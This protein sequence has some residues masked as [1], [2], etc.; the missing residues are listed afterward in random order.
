MSLT[1]DEMI[2]ALRTGPCTVTFKKVNGD[3]RV[4][5]CTLNMS[6]IPESDQ[7]KTD[8]N[9]SENKEVDFVKAYDLRAAGW[10]SFKVNNV[11]DFKS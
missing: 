7:P 10:R 1:R 2:N 3:E 8:G 9:L 11:T 6:M 5:D 4:M